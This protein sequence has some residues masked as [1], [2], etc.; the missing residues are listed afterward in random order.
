MYQGAFDCYRKIKK[1]EGTKAF[2][3]GGLSNV[4]KGIGLALV[5]VI[6]DEV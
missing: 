6:Y 1:D 3:K 5:L 4:Y 2:F